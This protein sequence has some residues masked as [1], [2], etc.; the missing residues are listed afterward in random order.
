[1]NEQIMAAIIDGN[2]SGL[3]DGADEW[4][5]IDGMLGGYALHGGYFRFGTLVVATTAGGPDSSNVTLVAQDYGTIEAASQCLGQLAGEALVHWRL[6]AI[7]ADSRGIGATTE[8]VF[9]S[10][11]ESIISPAAT[12]ATQHVYSV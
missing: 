3:F 1:M 12:T 7:T 11:G 10:G 4:S 6:A 2:V 8:P 5:T 9:A